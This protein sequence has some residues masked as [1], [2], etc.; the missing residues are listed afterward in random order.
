M[1]YFKDRVLYDNSPLLQAI[2]YYQ[3]ELRLGCI[4]L[5]GFQGFVN[6]KNQTHMQIKPK[7]FFLFS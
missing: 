3:K 2:K 1:C 7:V 5:F 6:F 4:R